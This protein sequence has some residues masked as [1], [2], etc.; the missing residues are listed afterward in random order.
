MEQKP[1]HTNRLINEKS[2]Y[3]LVR[4]RNSMENGEKLFKKAV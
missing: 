4:N 1:Q 3:L 2:P